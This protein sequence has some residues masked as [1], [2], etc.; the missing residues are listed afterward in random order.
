MS[1]QVLFMTTDGRI[2]VFLLMLL[3]C[4]TV[5]VKR[6]IKWTG[7]CFWFSLEYPQT[8]PSSPSPPPFL[9]GIWPDSLFSCALFDSWVGGRIGPGVCVCSCMCAWN[10]RLE[11]SPDRRQ[12]ACL[13][14]LQELTADHT[15]S[16]ESCPRWRLTDSTPSTFSLSLR[17]FLLSILQQTFFSINDPLLFAIL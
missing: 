9:Q 2:A 3:S 7:V 14:C 16:Q 8:L 5:A 17:L 12:D 4:P 10:S 11:Q 15:V 13:W 1:K 6:G